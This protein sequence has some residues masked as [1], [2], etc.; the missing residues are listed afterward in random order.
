[1]NSTLPACP[2]IVQRLA[3]LHDRGRVGHGTGD[4]EAADLA[5]VDKRLHARNAIT[6]EKPVTN[7]GNTPTDSARAN[8]SNERSTPPG[9]ARIRS[10]LTASEAE[11]D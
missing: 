6:H 3:I 4:D 1:M 11:A 9:S 7:C 5:L 10:P 2:Q 8:T